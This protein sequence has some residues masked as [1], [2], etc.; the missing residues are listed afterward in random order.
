MEFAA[1][2][3]CQLLIAHHPLLFDPVGVV[4]DQTI[5]GKTI[6]RLIRHDISFIAAHTNWD[7]ADGGINDA[8]ASRLGLTDV[9]PF[10]SSSF[11]EDLKLVAFVPAESVDSVLDACTEAGAGT[12]GLYRRCAFYHPGTGTFPRKRGHESHGRHGWSRWSK[13]T[14]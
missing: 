6:Q 10:G 2:N 5:Q 12:I 8:L 7:A 11:V 4:T 9:V 1:Q 13:P 3:G 14:K